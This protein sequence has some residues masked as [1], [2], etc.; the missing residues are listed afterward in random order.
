VWGEIT[1]FVA[2]HCLEVPGCLYAASSRL[3]IPQAL[4]GGRAVRPSASDRCCRAAR[5]CRRAAAA[6]RC[7]TR[8]ADTPAGRTRCPT[9]HAVIAAGQQIP[10]AKTE[11]VGHRRQPTTATTCTPPASRTARRTT[12]SGRSPGSGVASLGRGEVHGQTRSKRVVDY[13]CRYAAAARQF[14]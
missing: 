2:A 12:T 14:Y 13:S 3:R 1:G 8:R 10:V 7:V 11:I 6:T 9:I 5:L 4:T